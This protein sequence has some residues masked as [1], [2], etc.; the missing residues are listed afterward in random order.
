[1]KKVLLLLADGFETWEACV[2]IDVIGW[3]LEEGDGSTKLY[4]AGLRKEIK[5]S[6]D[7]RFIV[8]YTLDEV[9][10]DEFEA[11]AIPGGFETYGF[12]KDAY[13][14]SFLELIRQFKARD[15]F[16]ASICVGALPV[17]KSGILKG[18][19]GTV[20]NSKVRRD[21]LKSFGVEVLHQPIVEDDGIVTS[22]N[23]STAMDV[24][25]RLLEEL[26]SK[27]NTDKVR[28]LMGFK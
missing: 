10:I 19:K 4:T 25:Y 13:H 26:T 24:A 9:N 28:D 27:E 11:L 20:Y 23:P 17:A 2:F 21:A 3:N 6:F 7:Q 14:E 1:M 16:I 8:D 18:K 12:Y 5:S 15:K 22:W